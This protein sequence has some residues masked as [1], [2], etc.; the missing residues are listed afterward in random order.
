MS[1]LYML[2][3]L[4]ALTLLG[5]VQKFC[6][7]HSL[8]PL[9]SSLLHLKIPLSAIFSN[10]FIALLDLLK[11]ETVPVN[12]YGKSEMHLKTSL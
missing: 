10:V 6:S 11:G 8:V 1:P 9:T 2:F 7:F 12:A 4:V 3:V 5:K